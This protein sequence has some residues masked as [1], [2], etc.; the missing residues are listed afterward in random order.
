MDIIQSIFKRKSVIPEKLPAYG[1]SKKA[2]IYSYSTALPSS[3]F[4]MTVSITEQ[5]EISTMVT[6]PALN[7]PYVLHLADNAAGSFVG[8]VKYEYEQVLTDIADKCFE[9]DVFKTELA[10]AMIKYVRSKYSSE[11]EY[12]WQ[13]FPDNAVVRRKD[14]QKWYAAFLTVSRRKL[15]FASDET[16]EII[17]LRMAPENIEK[18][19][20]NVKILPGYHM[21]KK[22]WIT[23]CL[24]GSVPLDEICR[25]T[26][27]SYMLASKK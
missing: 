3:E 2:D 6:D 10:K 4:T 21:N 18:N 14:N 23:I 20:D 24:D 7:E 16:A 13:K 11:L 12:L 8:G 15:G 17:D 1:F 22:H 25:L 9:H 19:V 5:G 26:D 27:E